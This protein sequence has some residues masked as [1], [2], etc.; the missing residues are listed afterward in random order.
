MNALT[1]RGLTVGLMVAVWTFVVGYARLNVSVWASIVALGC[2]FA[3][4][5][6]LGGLQKTVAGT[7]SGVAWVLVANAVNVSVGANRLIAAIV[8]GAAVCVIVI[9]ARLPLLSFTAGALCGAAVA[10]AL[11]TSTVYGAI[12]A[13][14][15]LAVGAGLGFAA[16]RI[17]QAVR[18]RP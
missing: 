16:E 1:M 17:G 13:G 9:Q 6:G 4:G 5:G 3:S 10:T 15:A 7:L 18:P 8:L 11:G 14:V 12:R 2:F